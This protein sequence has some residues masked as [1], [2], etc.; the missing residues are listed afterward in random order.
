MNACTKLFIVITCKYKSNL[1][2]TRCDHNRINVK[3]EKEVF[4][5]I[6]QLLNNDTKTALRDNSIK[7]HS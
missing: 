7:N 6:G 5:K 3:V 4:P 1:L 2:R